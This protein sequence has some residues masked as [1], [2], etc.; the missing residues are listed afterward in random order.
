LT[1]FRD[2]FEGGDLFCL[3]EIAIADET[4]IDLWD[5]L[6]DAGQSQDLESMYASID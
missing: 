6:A 5:L 1:D 3:P 4:P 2:I